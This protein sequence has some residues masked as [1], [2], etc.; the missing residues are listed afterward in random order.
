MLAIQRSYSTMAESQHRDHDPGED[1][2]S[3]FIPQDPHYDNGQSS[4]R[5]R[6]ALP[7]MRP[8]HYPGDGLDFRR[9]VMSGSGGGGVDAAPAGS[10]RPSAAVT[11]DLT[12]DDNT[13]DVG[14]SQEAAGD[15]GSGAGPSEGAGSSRARRPPRFGRDIIEVEDEP[16]APHEQAGDSSRGVR[17]HGRAPG[18]PIRRPQFAGLR[19]P[20]RF[21]ARQPTPPDFDDDLE[22]VSERALSRP[23][24]ASRQ[25]TPAMPN[26]RSVTPYPGEAAPIDLTDDDDL[27]ITDTRTRGGGLNGAP[28]GITAGQGTRSENYGGGLGIGRIAD[29]LRGEGRGV[30]NRLLQRL[31]FDDPYG[32][33]QHGRPPRHHHHHNPGYRAG[34]GGP[35]PPH[36]AA[37]IGFG[38]VMMDFETPAFDL[39]LGVNRPPTPK[40][41]PPAAAEE[42]FTR[43]PGE[44]EEVVCPNCGDELGMG[45]S[46]EKQQVWCVKG[47]GHVYCGDCA[48]N[49]HRPQSKKGK[50]RASDLPA[51]TAATAVPP[52]PFKKCVVDGCG[53]ATGKS[54]MFQVYL[55]T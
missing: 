15:Y 35:P 36:A 25:R 9:P 41:E 40:Y 29:I 42:G 21:P 2:D 48:H 49:R 24:T 27:M 39:G 31:R 37:V 34:G 20:S 33:I 43:S 51:S 10:E 45:S 3:L 6:L 38:P 1:S 13:Q 17:S 18:E 14:T 46:E 54:N 53:K 50:A 8:Q 52:P 23:P 30:G 47:C 32:P 22:I 5:R 12:D 44:D 11:I 16:S 55:G 4:S 19:R 7:P 28:P 26:P